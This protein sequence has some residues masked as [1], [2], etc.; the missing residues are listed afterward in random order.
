MQDAAINEKQ[1][2]S[3]AEQMLK[4]LSLESERLRLAHTSLQEHFKDVQL[5]L[6]ETNTKLYAKIAELDFSK[7]YLES[8]LS[9]ITQGI[10]FIDLNGMVTTCNSAAE[11]ILGMASPDILYHTFGDLFADE[12]FGFSFKQALQ[13]KK[14]PQGAF[15]TWEGKQG[16]KVELE[17]EVAFVGTNG[18]HSAV[19]GPSSQTSI[20]GV[21]ILLH[22][23]TEFRRLQIAANRVDR[24]K[25]LGEMAAHVAHEIRN[26]LG[27]IRGFASL[28]Q[29]DLKDKPE[30]EQMAGQIVEATDGLNKVVTQVLNYTRSLQPS[31]E[32]LDL[33]PFLDEIIQLVCADKSFNPKI[34]CQ[35]E[36]G[37]KT[38]LIPGDANLLKSAF[39]NLLVNALQAMPEGGILKTSLSQRDDKAVI[40]I[41]D[42]GVGIAEENLDKIFSPFFTTKEKG[43]GLGLAEVYKVIQAHSGVI[44]VVS[45]VGK[46]TTFTLKIP[47]KT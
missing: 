25:D 9:N 5:H 31:Y 32:S 30:L 42:T 11:K 19:A 13:S 20:Q 18:S 10:L 46:G 12:A 24:L 45:C 17:V 29:Q 44:E 34:D 39:L 40:A 16:D 14:A 3:A 21:L 26:P 35:Y 23:M 37:S 36:V 47:I 28:L 33:V 22:N 6:E 43:N 27:G 4:T 15:L 8:I 7:S 2:E 38:L 41:S 1:G